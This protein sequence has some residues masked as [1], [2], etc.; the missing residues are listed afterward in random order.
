MSPDR[1]RDDPDT[2]RVQERA[3]DRQHERA[4]RAADIY[5]RVEGLLGEQKYPTTSEELAVEYGDTMLDLPNETESL[6][7]VFDRLVDERFE[8]AA[9]A[10]E[11]VVDELDGEAIHPGEG[12][13][14]A[15]AD[16]D[17][18]AD[19]SWNDEDTRPR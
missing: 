8:S 4:S 15:S 12:D 11:A 1:R 14:S 16:H 17:R 6:G 5:E 7:S 13:G 2:E 10:R 3:I 18:E 9:E 19:W